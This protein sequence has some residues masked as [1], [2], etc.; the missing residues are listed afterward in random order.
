MSDLNFTF[1]T[2]DVNDPDD[3]HLR[4][5]KWIT[6]LNR[7]FLHTK[8]TEDADK[9]NVLLMFAGYDLE[10]YRPGQLCSRHKDA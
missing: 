4:W 10:M 7:Y 9:L 8:T 6:R 3:L 2:F 5:T 1:E